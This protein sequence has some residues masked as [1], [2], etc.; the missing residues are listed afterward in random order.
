MS[1]DKKIPELDKLTGRIVILL[2]TGKKA[3]RYQTKI[4]AKPLGNW[5]DHVSLSS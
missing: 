3:L 2:W 1:R 4:D 5:S